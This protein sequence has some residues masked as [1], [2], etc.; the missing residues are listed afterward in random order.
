MAERQQKS[1]DTII[2]Q[3]IEDYTQYDELNQ[4]KDMNEREMND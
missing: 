3:A 2:K 1:L 4:D